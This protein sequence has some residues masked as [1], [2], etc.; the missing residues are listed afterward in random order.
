MKKIRVT[1]QL[2]LKTE[3]LRSLDASKSELRE[4]RGGGGPTAG[5]PCPTR[6][7]DNDLR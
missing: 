1:R 4:V 6:E 3:V 5:G 7:L 2:T